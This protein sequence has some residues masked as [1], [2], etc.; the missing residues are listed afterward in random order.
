MPREDL[1]RRRF[2]ERTTSITLGALTLGAHSRCSARGAPA[3]L[4][5]GLSGEGPRVENVVIII[6]D[7]LRRDALKVYGGSW[8]ETPRLERFASRSAVFENAYLSSFPTVPARNDVLTG[9][10]TFTRKPWSPIDPDAVTL[11]ETARKADIHTALIADTPHP[12]QPGYNYQRGF[13]SWRVIRGQEGDPFRSSPREP[14]L[15]CAKEKLR[16]PEGAVVQYLRNVSRRRGEEDHFVARTMRAAAAWLEENRRSGRFLLYVDTFDPHEPWDPP[17]HYVERYDPGYAGEEVIY[18]RYDRWRDFLSEAELKHCRALYAAEAALVDRWIGFLLERLE[19]LG[20]LET[21]AVFIL[22][23]HGFYLGEH[24][25]IGK[26]LLRGKLFQNLPLYPEV[27]RIPFLVRA[28]GVAPGKVA[29]FAQPVDIMPTALEL[30]GV[31]T[32]ESVEGRSLVPLL[33]RAERAVR[34]LAISSPTLSHPKLKVPHPTARATV[35]DGEWLLVSGPRVE[36][37]G[38]GEETEAVDNLLRE[39]A[40]LQGQVGPEL[41]RLSSDPGCEKDLLS[42]HPGEAARLHGEL[43]RFLEQAKVPEVHLKHFRAGLPR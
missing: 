22:S 9:R 38:A 26:A 32:P 8:I 33:T 28:P 23:D 10:H 16:N 34:P 42:A 29:G 36:R 27:C 18:P 17:R 25:Y 13:H 31:P 14:K 24:G 4:P 7:T 41:Y 3:P 11:Q 5:A 12:F 20:L 19:E 35:T 2:L 37:G 43:V 40:D 1:T 21:T 30:L 39:V 15:P 6:S